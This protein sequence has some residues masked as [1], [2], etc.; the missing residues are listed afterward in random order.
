M[1]YLFIDTAW[2]FGEYPFV[3]PVLSKSLQLVGVQQRFRFLPPMLAIV[4][5]RDPVVLCLWMVVFLFQKGQA[6]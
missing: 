3:L 6:K 1:V 2:R 4:F 5:C